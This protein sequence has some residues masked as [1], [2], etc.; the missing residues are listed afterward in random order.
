MYDS[1]MNTYIVFGIMAFV[2]MVMGVIFLNTLNNV[3]V[4]ESEEN[5]YIS[6]HKTNCDEKL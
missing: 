6:N 5:K 4:S 1:G 3:R 2:V